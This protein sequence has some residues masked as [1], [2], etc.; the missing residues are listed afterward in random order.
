MCH[1]SGSPTSRLRD[2]YP[3]SG[4]HSQDQQL[5]GGGGGR[6]RY[7]AKEPPWNWNKVSAHSLGGSAVGMV[8]LNCLEFGQI[9]WTL[10]HTV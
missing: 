8:I 9:A 7:R 10:I 5:A 1:R 6:K 4:I 3:H 2:E